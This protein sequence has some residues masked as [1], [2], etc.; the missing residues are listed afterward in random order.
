MSNITTEKLDLKQLTD[1]VYSSTFNSKISNIVCDYL[2]TKETV[3]SGL[4]RKSEP[5]NVVGTK[6]GKKRL[7]RL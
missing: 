3:I 6:K 4:K 5:E 7:R 2:F 1:I